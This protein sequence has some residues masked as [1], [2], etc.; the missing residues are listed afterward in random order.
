M[1]HL[2]N[3]ENKKGLQGHRG[4]AEQKGQGEDPQATDLL[5]SLQKDIMNDI[6]SKVS[7]SMEGVG[8]NFQ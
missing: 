3:S 8:E 4:T 2:V 1:T 5:T 6:C 7:L